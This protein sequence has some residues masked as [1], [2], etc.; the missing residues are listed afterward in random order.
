MYKSSHAQIT[1]EIEYPTSDGRPMAETDFHRELMTDMVATLSDHYAAKSN[2]YVS[3][4]LLLFYVRG[5]K[6]KHISPDTFVVVGVPKHKRQNYLLWEERKRPSIVIEFTSSS[7]RREDQTKKFE[8]YRD[9]IKVPEYL[10]FDPFGDYLKP[11]FQGYRR[12]ASEY[13]PIPIVDGQ[14]VSKQLDLIFEPDGEHLRV[15]DPVT[16]ER[17][18]T[19]AEDRDRAIAENERLRVENEELRR[20]L[21]SRDD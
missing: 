3:G 11:R 21:A 10:L 20:R 17:L 14:L 7:T 12:V 6:R 19:P 4:N 13:R 9:V 15:V 1:R 8:L 18:P 5:N 16:G 2:V